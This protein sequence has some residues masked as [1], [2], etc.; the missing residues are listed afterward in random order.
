LTHGFLAAQLHVKTTEV[1]AQGEQ[2]KAEAAV[3]M[4]KGMFGTALDMALR[5][6]A[7]TKR[8]LED[9]RKAVKKPEFKANPVC[10]RHRLVLGCIILYVQGLNT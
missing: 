7:G 5:Q 8:L 4:Q 3:E 10:E 2:A 1:F 9:D 6:V